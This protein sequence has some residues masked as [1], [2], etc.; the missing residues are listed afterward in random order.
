MT[1][2]LVCPCCNACTVSPGFSCEQPPTVAAESPSCPVSSCFRLRGP[3]WLARQ[4]RVDLPRLPGQL[5]VQPC[6]HRCFGA[7]RVFLSPTSLSF[8]GNAPLCHKAR[9]WP[10][11]LVR[12]GLAAGIWNVC[13]ERQRKWP[14]RPVAKY[15]TRN[16]GWAAIR[17]GPWS[18][19]RADSELAAGKGCCGTLR[20]ASPLFW[21]PPVSMVHIDPV[22]DICPPPPPAFRVFRPASWNVYGQWARDG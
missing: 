9:A 1:R 18:I 14:G 3:S 12:P 13:G 10:G 15:R 4:G 17:D 20:G 16:V 21:G 8:L 11:R 19:R 6:P 7:H 2:V 5:L 22:S